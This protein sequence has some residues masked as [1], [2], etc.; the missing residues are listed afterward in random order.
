MWLR[1]DEPELALGDVPDAEGRAEVGERALQL[2]V[3]AR[4]S[5]SFL[6][7]MRRS[8]RTTAS[9]CRVF[10]T[11]AKLSATRPTA[12]T[13]STMTNATK[14]RVRRERCAARLRVRGAR[15]A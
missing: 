7:L 14:A 12:R 1:V 10:C 3:L 4:P 8:S 6:S 2:V 11:T 5:W 9:V 15:Y 13:V